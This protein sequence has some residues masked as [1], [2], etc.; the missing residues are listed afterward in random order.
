MKCDFCRR[1]VKGEWEFCPHCGGKIRDNFE[2]FFSDIF[3]KVRKEMQE[4]DKFFEVNDIFLDSEVKPKTFTIEINT[5][6]KDDP[7][8]KIVPFRK[9]DMKKLRKPSISMGSRAPKSTEE[10]ETAISSSDSV[11]NIDIKLPGVKSENSIEIK[12]LESSIEVKASSGKKIFFKIIKKPD[13][14]Q[15]MKSKFRNGVL[16]LELS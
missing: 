4:L 7:S 15:L 14:Y 16:H 12:E 13:D 9:E 8:V 3:K 2:D 11:I 6:N 10:P 1:Q 5:L